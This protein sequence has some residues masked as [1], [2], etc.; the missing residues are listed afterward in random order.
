MMSSVIFIILTSLL[1]PNQSMWDLG[2]IIEKDNP[3]TYQKELDVNNLVE[4]VITNNNIKALHSNNFIPPIIHEI[5]NPML[6]NNNI[7]KKYDAMFSKI[8]LSDKILSIKKSFLNKQYSSFFNFYKL[9]D[10]KN[11]K[12]D[13]IINLM[14]IQNLYFSNQFSG[15]KEALND[16]NINQLSEDLLLYKIKIDIKLKNIEDAISTIDYF[17]NKF[18]NSD[19]MPYVIYEKKLINNINNE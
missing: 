5:K 1:F 15:A 8:S 10:N 4:P 2:V 11:V 6:K 14:Y 19:L 13:Q 12:T 7:L 9:I 3:I 18:P 17:S 16:V